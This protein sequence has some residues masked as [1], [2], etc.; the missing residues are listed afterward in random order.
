LGDYDVIHPEDVE[1]TVSALLTMGTKGDH[2]RIYSLLD[3][4]LDRFHRLADEDRRGFKDVLDRFVRTYS[5]LSQVVSFG[6]TKLERDYLYCRALA[7]LLRSANTVERLDLGTQVE[8]THL[9]QEA[10]FSGSLYVNV[11]AGEVKSFTSDGSGQQRLPEMEPLSQ[12][13][14]TLNERFGLELTE[15]DQLLFDQYERDWLSDPEV[16]DQARNNTIEN[17]KL[18]FNRNFLKTVIGRMDEN[19]ALFKRILDD[20]EFQ[21]AIKEFY[22][23]KIYQRAR[24]PE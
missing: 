17:F 5:F 18:V 22:G 14:D 20:S 12:I 16:T 3:P 2:G 23:T 11:E 24:R 9:R 19:D 1:G 8:L 4:A 6:D 7:S 15:T 21:E 13:V 10:T